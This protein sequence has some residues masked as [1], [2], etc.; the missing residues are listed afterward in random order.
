MCVGTC[1]ASDGTNRRTDAALL[2]AIAR[3]VLQTLVLL[4]TRRIEL[5]LSEED[6]SAAAARRLSLDLDY[7]LLARAST[8]VGCPLSAVLFA[9]LWCLNR[10]T[11]PMCCCGTA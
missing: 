11:G 10:C 4:R 1:S 6:G 2:Y 5:F 7:R 8:A 3:L 9:E